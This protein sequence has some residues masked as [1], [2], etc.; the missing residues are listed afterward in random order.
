MLLARAK[1]YRSGRCC[2]RASAIESK[3]LR[4]SA[5]AGTFA[6]VGLK[7][8]AL[9]VVLTKLRSSTLYRVQQTQRVD[10]KKIISVVQHVITDEYRPHPTH[11]ADYLYDELGLHIMPISLLS[12]KHCSILVNLL[13]GSSKCFMRCTSTIFS[14]WQTYAFDQLLVVS[15]W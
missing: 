6:F 11:L 10:T 2:I 1:E 4:F 7:F 12:N 5:A 9:W 14:I 8:V 15:D 3:V 13:S